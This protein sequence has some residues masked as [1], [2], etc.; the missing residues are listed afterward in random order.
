MSNPGHCRGR[1]SAPKRVGGSVLPSLRRRT[2][3][4]QPPELAGSKCA[5]PKQGLS[6]RLVKK[7]WVRSKM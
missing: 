6:G 1:G 4:E 2:E 7:P 5:A 3:A